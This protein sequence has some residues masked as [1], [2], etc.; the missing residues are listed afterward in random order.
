[1]EDQ[2]KPKPLD[3]SIIDAVKQRRLEERGIQSEIAS[4]AFWRQAKRHQIRLRHLEKAANKLGFD[5]Q[6]YMDTIDRHHRADHYLLKKKLS[7]IR[8]KT[9]AHVQE[10][11]KRQKA[12]RERYLA[13]FGEQIKKK[14]GNPEL[15]FAQPVDHWIEW[16]EPISGMYG[17]RLSADFPS[18]EFNGE[19][20][21]DYGD[22]ITEI[23]RFFPMV[24]LDNGDEDLCRGATLSQN[25]MLRQSL[26]S[27][28]G[29]FEV[30]DIKVNLNGTGYSEWTEGSSC[31][32]LLNTC[33]RAG[34]V[35]ALTLTV[36]VFHTNLAGLMET[37][38][39]EGLPLF[40]RGDDHSAVA[41]VETGATRY[42]VTD[43]ML[44]SPDRGGFD[45]VWV[46]I[47]LDTH[48]TAANRHGRGELS[49]ARPDHEGLSLGC[50]ALR[51][52]YG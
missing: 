22:P 37:T 42:P 4:L 31:P 38:P 33:G 41:S 12:V 8:A 3:R 10:T 47:R 43:F 35:T 28:R 45:E 30:A 34:G 49:F 17:G 6:E 24:C 52:E 25:L 29:D 23:H 50:V 2:N 13:T 16:D 11:A 7:G 26:A 39:I 21:I 32:F 18:S 48:V 27:G 19:M 44:T 51:G 1:M 40:F 9:R 5:V 15:K 14:A 46:L 20:E 36:T